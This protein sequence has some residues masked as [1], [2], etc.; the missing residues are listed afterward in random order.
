MNS[1]SRSGVQSFSEKRTPLLKSE[2]TAAFQRKAFDQ[3]RDV[4]VW[5]DASK[6]GGLGYVVAQEEGE[7]T[8]DGNFNKLVNEKGEQRYYMVTCGSSS[9]TPAQKNYSIL[10]LEMSAIVYALTNARHWLIGAPNPTST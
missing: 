8:E 9:L 3:K 4:T 7:W 5:T 6:E 1:S 2:I 10:E